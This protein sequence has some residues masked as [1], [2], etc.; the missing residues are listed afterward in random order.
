MNLSG[1]SMIEIFTSLSWVR[2]DNMLYRGI[3]CGCRLSLVVSGVLEL[4]Y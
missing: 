2:V 3:S 1:K 4:V